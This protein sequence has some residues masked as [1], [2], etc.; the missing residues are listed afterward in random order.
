MGTSPTE[1]LNKTTDSLLK[2]FNSEYFTDEMLI[3]YYFKYF[4]TP[5][6]HDYLTN[7]LYEMDPQ[8]L[9]IYAPYLCHMLVKHESK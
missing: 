2:M 3:Q 8:K 6:T 9:E 7:K 4:D 5:G 1:Q